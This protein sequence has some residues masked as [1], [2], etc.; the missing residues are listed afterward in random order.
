MR[1]A[2]ARRRIV[3]RTLATLRAGL[4]V[5]A[6]VGI[7]LGLNGC[8]TL[9]TAGAPRLESLDERRVRLALEVAEGAYAVHPSEASLLFASAPFAEFG[10]LGDGE[11]RPGDGFVLHAQLLWVPKPGTT[12]IDPTATNVTL[13]WVVF[14]AGEVG[15]YGGAGFCWPDGEV[16]KD[17]LVLDIEA[18]TLSL[19]AS[20]PGFV[21]RA[22]P[23]SISGRF[24]APYRPAAALEMRQRVSRLVTEA[25]GRAYWVDAAPSRRHLAVR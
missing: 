13:R 18:S 21:D 4:T 7:A 12:P 8:G 3:D 24:R 11:A 23:A 9:F 16:G 5:A 10:G 14:S 20:T 19:I 2:A 25:V 22:S 1:S 6:G 15:V 17:P